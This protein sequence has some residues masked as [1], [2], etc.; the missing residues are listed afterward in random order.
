MAKDSLQVWK[1]SEPEKGAKSIP[2][3][4]QGNDG[5]YLYCAKFCDNDI[6]LAGGSGT[7]SAQA[8]NTE[9]GEVRIMRK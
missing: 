3:H 5:A 4:Y 6:V 7:N 2:F 1:Y 9:T 8:I